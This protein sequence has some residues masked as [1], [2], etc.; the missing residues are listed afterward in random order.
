M[1]NNISMANESFG[2]FRNDE[3]QNGRAK[4]A[5]DLVEQMS[6]KESSIGKQAVTMMVE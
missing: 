6:S 5:E 1:V 4:D 2:N 3:K